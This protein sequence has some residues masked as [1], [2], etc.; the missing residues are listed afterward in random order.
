MF[1]T[2]L[3]SITTFFIQVPQPE[4]ASIDIEHQPVQPPSQPQFPSQLE[5]VVQNHQQW[6]NAIVGFCFSYALGVSLQSVSPSPPDHR[7]P[8]PT[9]LLSFLVLLVFIFILLAFFIHPK[10]IMISQAL[11]KAALLLAA[12][13]FCHA[14]S[15]PFSTEIKC[16]VRPLFFLSLLGAMIFTYLNIKKA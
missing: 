2:F 5:P 9:V 16:A 11:Q 10:C 6:Q 7:L 15:I 1:Q 12:T 3:S 4:T 13:A 14:L 8:L